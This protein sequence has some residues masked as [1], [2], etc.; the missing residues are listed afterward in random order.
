MHSLFDFSIS[1]WKL[2]TL[3]LIFSSRERSKF[4]EYF[5]KKF[6]NRNSKACYFKFRTQSLM[7]AGEK[8][9][10]WEENNLLF[11]LLQLTGALHVLAHKIL[12]T[13]RSADA[14]LSDFKGSPQIR[15]SIQAKQYGLEDLICLTRIKF[16]NSKTFASW[17]EAKVTNFQFLIFND[18]NSLSESQIWIISC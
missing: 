14:D 6:L 2:S 11:M 12:F 10:K 18:T 1:F 7:N 4:Y 16:T 5:Y 3:F 15:Y 9:V 8:R 13:V 17:K